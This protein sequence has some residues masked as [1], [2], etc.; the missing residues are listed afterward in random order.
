MFMLFSP[1]G[2]CDKNVE[3]IIAY[4]CVKN[5]SLTDHFYKEKV[6]N[7]N[8]YSNMSWI[9]CVKICIGAAQ[10]L[11]YLHT[12]TSVKHKVIHCNVKS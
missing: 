11:D 10:G 2:Y 8:N 5:G 1:T 7:C 3:M 9:K 6:K 12:D 4:E